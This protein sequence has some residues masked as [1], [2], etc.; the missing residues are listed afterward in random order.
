MPWSNFAVLYRDRQF[1]I[2][3]NALHEPLLLQRPLILEGKGQEKT[4]TDKSS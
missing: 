3:Q 4:I 2:A 1:P